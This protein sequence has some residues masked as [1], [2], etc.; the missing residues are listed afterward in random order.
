MKYPTLTHYIKAKV[1]SFIK[2]QI[3]DKDQMVLCVIF[4]KVGILDINDTLALADRNVC[5]HLR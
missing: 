2:S 5:V 3:S 4:N 1:I